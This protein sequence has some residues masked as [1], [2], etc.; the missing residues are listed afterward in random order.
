MCTATPCAFQLNESCDRM[1]RQDSIYKVTI[2]LEIT[3]NA[4]N[5]MEKELKRVY[6]GIIGGY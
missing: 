2:I 1:R 6:G 5:L 4:E 3:G